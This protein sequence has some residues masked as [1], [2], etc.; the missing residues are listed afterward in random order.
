[1]STTI[2][3]VMIVVV[4]LTIPFLL[5]WWRAADRWADAEHKRFKPRNKPKADERTRPDA[6]VIR[7]PPSADQD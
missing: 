6:Q 1:V 3:A 2:A 7:R 4:A 5:L